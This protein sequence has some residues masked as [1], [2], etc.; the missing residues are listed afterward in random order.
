MLIRSVR[1]AYLQQNDQHF[2]KRDSAG[3]SQWLAASDPSC[4]GN[5]EVKH[6]LRQLPSVLAPAVAVTDSG[7]A[8]AGSLDLIAV[9]VSVN[10]FCDCVQ[11]VLLFERRNNIVQ[12]FNETVQQV[13][14]RISALR[15]ALD[16]PQFD[17]QGLVNTDPR[18]IAVPASYINLIPTDIQ[19]ITFSRTPAQ[20][21]FL[22]NYF[23]P[24]S[25]A[26][27][28]VLRSLHCCRY[29]VQSIEWQ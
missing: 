19:G 20:A 6:S 14:S 7:N 1:S 10:M 9:M 5:I 24:D 18:N 22:C 8:A 3:C 23:L 17:D 12:P 11:R 21:S 25:T 28:C 13:F 4:I 15:D 16:G 26:V 29:I 27:Q 2:Y